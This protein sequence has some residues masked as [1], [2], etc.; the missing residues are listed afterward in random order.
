[1]STRLRIPEQGEHPEPC[2]DCPAPCCHTVSVL[3]SQV[4]AAADLDL[5]EQYVAYRG[6]TVWLDD[7]G[8]FSINIVAKCA[9]LEAETYACG[10]HGTEL[11]PRVCSDFDA[12]SCWYRAASAPRRSGSLKLDAGSWPVVRALVEVDGAGLVQAYPTDAAGEGAQFDVDVTL[13]FELV[14]DS[15]SNDYLRFLCNFDKI[16]VVRGPAGWAMV[17]PTRR[18]RY[19]APVNNEITDGILMGTPPSDCV[20]LGRNELASLTLSTH[21]A[22]ERLTVEEIRAALAA[23]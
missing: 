10:V 15:L 4:I 21:K 13:A 17:Y 16:A 19:S 18:M 8:A 22:I 3:K 14:T 2:N 20:V 5:L 12:S 11:Q 1:M 9:H 23:R 7:S 6:I